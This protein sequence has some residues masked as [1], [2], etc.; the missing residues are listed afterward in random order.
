MLICV[1]FHV[2]AGVFFIAD[3]LLPSMRDVSD[4]SACD[5]SG[6][7]LYAHSLSSL[8]LPLYCRYL[9]DPLSRSVGWLNAGWQR[10]I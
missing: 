1:V 6:V 2:F 3:D 5:M 8:P 9:G 7:S 4:M 10:R